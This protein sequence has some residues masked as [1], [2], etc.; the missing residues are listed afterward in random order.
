MSRK[1]DAFYEVHRGKGD[2]LSK[3]LERVIS[4]STSL[5]RPFLRGEVL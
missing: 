4:F 1:S 3:K 5:P 2:S